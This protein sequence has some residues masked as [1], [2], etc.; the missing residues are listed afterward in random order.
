[1]IPRE[2]SKLIRQ[3]FNRGRV[4]CFTGAG[5]SAESGIPTFR[6]KG[7]LW[8]KYDPQKYAYPQGLI[9]VLRDS[10]GDFVNF[11]SE[12]YSL[13]FK[14]HPNPAHVVLATLEKEN[15]IT[16]VI[17][18]NVDNLHQQAGSRN[19]IE[20]HGN[21]YRIKCAGC[22]R[23]ITMEKDRAQEMAQLLKKNRDSYIK[24]LKI[25]SRYFPRC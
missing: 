22:G 23:P 1:M 12:F 17:T 10:P 6:G 25:L 5:I 3:G 21:A 13:L 4:A 24:I 19:V 20:L 15:R 14:A 11:V 2:I 9:S 7:G 16:A 8:E 18:Q